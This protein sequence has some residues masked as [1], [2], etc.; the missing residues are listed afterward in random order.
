M[1]TSTPKNNLTSMYKLGPV[2]DTNINLAKRIESSSEPR[3]TKTPN[4]STFALI[5][6]KA[7]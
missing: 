7:V 5:T 1:N 6:L 2:Y 4:R 3:K